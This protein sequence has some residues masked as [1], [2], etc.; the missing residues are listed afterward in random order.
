MTE[1]KKLN[2]SKNLNI[3]ILRIHL[4]ISK[5]LLI[6]KLDVIDE[7]KFVAKDYKASE[8]VIWPNLFINKENLDN[9][10]AKLF[11]KSYLNFAYFYI[12]PFIT[13]AI[14]SVFIY[15]KCV[16]VVKKVLKLKSFYSINI[17]IL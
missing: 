3:L 17:V 15:P 4:N 5:L 2:Y 12:A 1:I 10:S 13:T 11:L 14:F 9:N 16:F 6:L 7:K 8:L